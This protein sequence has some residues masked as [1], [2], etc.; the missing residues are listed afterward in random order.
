MFFGYL[1]LIFSSLF[2]LALIVLHFLKR[3]LDPSQ[4]LINEYEI[5][6]YGWLM[7]AAFFSWAAGLL[8]AL[9]AMWPTLFS[10]V[11]VFARWWFLVIVLSLIG[12]GVFKAEPLTGQTS[13]RNNQLQRLFGAIILFTFPLMAAFATSS[14]V[15]NPFWAPA[16]GWL[17]L[18]VIL[19]WL[20]LIAFLASVFVTRKM[21]ARTAKK[22]GPLI[23]QGWMNRIN[24]AGDVFWLLIVAVSAIKLL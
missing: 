15:K 23:Y 7:Q 24:V 22:V 4:G 16:S 19:C 2:L 13:S 3:E 18:G 17:I 1:A 10:G 6:E 21:D 8:F 20:G 12:V 9:I 14:L 11:G 5:G